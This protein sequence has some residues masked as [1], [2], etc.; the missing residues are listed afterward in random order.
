NVLILRQP[1]GDR[2]PMLAVVGGLVHVRVKIIPVE[3]ARRHVSSALIGVRGLDAGD[4]GP[5]RQLRRANLAPMR[6]RVSRY[7]H[8][9]IIRARP[10][11]AVRERRERNRGDRVEHLL[12]GHI[13]ADRATRPRL[14]ALVIAREIR[15]DRLPMNALSVVSSSTF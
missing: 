2:R 6:S 1:G 10:D 12:A 13:G 14:L 15:T 4:R 5:R 9:A 8:E 3:P 7:M 11:G